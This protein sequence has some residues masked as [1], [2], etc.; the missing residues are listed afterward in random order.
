L[1]RLAWK[2]R[3]RRRCDRV[4]T[5]LAAIDAIFLEKDYL[6]GRQGPLVPYYWFIRSTPPSRHQHVRPFLVAFDEAV[7][8]N[9]QLGKLARTTKLVDAELSRYERLNRSIND[10]GSIEGRVRILSGRFAEY[11][12]TGSVLVHPSD[13]SDD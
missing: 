6:L 4:L 10:V 5:E 2:V 9:R 12:G 8:A 11:V 7:A 3:R 13:D 1:P